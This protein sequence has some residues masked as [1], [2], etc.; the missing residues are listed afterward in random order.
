MSPPS[1]AWYRA[2]VLGLSELALPKY[3]P[4]VGTKISAMRSDAVRVAIKVIGR[5]AMNSPT[6]PGQKSRGAKAAR[7]VAVEAM[8]GH[9][10]RLEA[11]P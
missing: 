4:K 8:I 2:A 11:S 6:I 1:M 9:A 10:M 7:V 3:A 5:K